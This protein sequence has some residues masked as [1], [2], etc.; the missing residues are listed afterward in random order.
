MIDAFKSALVG[1]F[2]AA[3]SM[4]KAAVEQ[5]P[6]AHWHGLVGTQPFSHVAYHTLFYTD[7][8][9]SPDEASYRRPELHREEYQV[10]GGTKLPPEQEPISDS[11][12]PREVILQYVELCRRKA[13]ENIAAETEETLAGPS[14]FPW[15][16]ISRA[17]FLLNNV[18]HIQHHTAHMSLYLRRVA[19]IEIRWVQTG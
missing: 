2:H 15:Y 5:C 1:Q 10:F 4:L 11:P 17:E 8:Y 16:K 14:G 7:F 13:S 12:I 9:L 19:E 6:E 18:R 3:L